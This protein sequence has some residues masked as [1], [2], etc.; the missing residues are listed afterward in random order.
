MGM[1]DF[2][3]GLF[4]SLDKT[5]SKEQ[6]NKD[7]ETLKNQLNSVEIQAKLG[8]DV[9]AN[10]TRQLNATQITLS[11]VSI[12]Q[13]TINRMVSQINSAL[14]NIQ[15]GNISSGSA[16]Q[17]AQRVGQQIGQQ[18]QQGVRSA[19]KNIDVGTISASIDKNGNI[20]TQIETI[21]NSFTKLGV[22][23]DEVKGKMSNLDTEISTLRNLLNNGASKTAIA[24]QFEKVNAVLK[25]T[26]NDLKQTRSEYSLLI[27]EQ[28]RLSYA[29]YLE[30]WKQKNTNAT[31]DAIEKIDK[32]IASL[33]NL[34][35]QMTQIEFGKIQTGFKNTENS[36]RGLDKLGANLKDKF[37]QAA[38]SFTQWVS[39]S[40]ALMGLVYKTKQAISEIKEVDTI[41]T[42]IR[43]TSD[44]TQEQLETLGKSAYSHASK[45]GLK[46]SN[47]LT[48]VQE[49]NRSG[50]YGQQGEDLA[51]TSTLA[52]SAGDMTAEVANNWILATNSAYKYEGEAKKLNTVLDG[53]NEITNRN[54]VNM[55]DMADAMTI[56]G[57]NAAN[58]GVKVNELS[59][60]IGTA[61]ATTKKSGSEIG[62]AFKTI[63]VNLQNTSSSKIIATLK[64]AGTSM[65]EMVDGV[66][67]LR[68]PISILKDLAKTYNSLD[69]SDPLRADITRNVGGKYYANILG[70]TLDNWNQYSKMLEDYSDGGGSAMEE[71]EK[72]SNNLEGSLN[73]LSNTWTSTV[74]NIVN[75]KDLT[76][77]VKT[78]NSMLGAI[79]D[80][81]S[82][83]KGAGSIGVGVG[84]IQSLTGH[85]E[86]V[87]RP[88][89]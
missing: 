52:Q 35:T 46:A 56:V 18:V 75:S 70:S 67:R 7:I 74:N 10:L 65:T 1:N 44:S 37:S 41:L 45:F 32:Y 51:D 28:R 69:K 78:L 48:G 29:N 83:L 2:Q 62:T 39:V 21:R 31:R 58:A 68:S 87:L 42:E 4:G 9:V 54:S 55:T 24:T 61:V 66:E 13:V 71:A 23:A 86:I 27:S 17:S 84:L 15:I 5:K 43:K 80:I 12:D 20:A 50:F 14:G 89:F 26:Q 49:M 25:Q 8:K 88:S 6:L 82:A 16:T 53:A 19:T 3:L 60:I 81:T 76:N 64:D 77:T 40:S 33:R 63:F 36:M 47:W 22:S 11:N 72:S 38:E 59:A 85:G 79:N 34:N 73:K 57:S 30:G